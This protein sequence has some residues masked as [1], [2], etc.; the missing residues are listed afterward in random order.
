MAASSYARFN[1]YDPEAMEFIKWLI[2]VASPVV[3]EFDAT[4]ERELQ[5]VG[6]AFSMWQEF[7]SFGPRQVTVHLTLQGTLPDGVEYRPTPRVQD[8]LPPV[9][10]ALP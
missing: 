2:G 1:P 8:A 3:T 7:R 6:S 9:T 5:E 4:I 10:K